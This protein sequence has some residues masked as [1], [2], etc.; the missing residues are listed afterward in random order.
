MTAQPTQLIDKSQK[1][2]QDS[3]ASPSL[4]A[5][6]ACPHPCPKMR[7]QRL[8]A[9]VLAAAAVAHTAVLARNPLAKDFQP[10]AGDHAAACKHADCGEHLIVTG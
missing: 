4:S 3:A 5:W 9:A 1:P 7:C 10:L 6:F 8:A 2:P